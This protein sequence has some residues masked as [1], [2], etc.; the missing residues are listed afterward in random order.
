VDL[1]FVDSKVKLIQDLFL[2]DLKTEI[3]YFEQRHLGNCWP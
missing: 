2:M 1:I 3:L